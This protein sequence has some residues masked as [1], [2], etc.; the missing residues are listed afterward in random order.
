MSVLKTTGTLRSSDSMVSKSNCVPC[1]KT[2]M[3]CDI[4]FTFPKST[5]AAS[6]LRK[7]LRGGLLVP[8][9]RD[10][11]HHMQVVSFPDFVVHVPR[12]IAELVYQYVGSIFVCS[13]GVTVYPPP[14][15]AFDT[16]WSD[17]HTDMVQLARAWESEHA[18]QIASLMHERE[19]MVHEKE[20]RIANGVSAAGKQSVTWL[21][22][23]ICCSVLYGLNHIIMS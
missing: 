15:F 9:R 12:V 3:T 1:V 14:V 17:T 2:C 6:H 7:H 23:F 20:R 4:C 8:I 16:A 18:H 10:S 22:C 13:C 11:N 19:C 5:S 21:W